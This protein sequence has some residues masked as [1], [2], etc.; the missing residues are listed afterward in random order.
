MCFVITANTTPTDII[1]KGNQK[2]LFPRLNDG[3]FLYEQGL[4]VK[5]DELNEKLKTI[6]FQKELGSI[7]DKV[8][9]I[10][11]H[12]EV[13]QRHL[14]IGD[15]TKAKR[16]AELCKADIASEMVFEFPELQGIIGRTMLWHKG[17]IR[18]WHKP[19]K[20]IGCRAVRTLLFQK[21][22]QAH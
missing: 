16:A 7:Y 15:P 3:V 12:T 5:L 17:K 13:L 4:K 14:K 8:K 9:R 1:R 18:K 21:L 10:M 19:L 22:K 20:S 2:A 6:T 11:H